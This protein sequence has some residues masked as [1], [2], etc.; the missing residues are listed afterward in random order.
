MYGKIV[1]P[2]NYE[3]PKGWSGVV[4][5]EGEIAEGGNQI[6]TTAEALEKVIGQLDSKIET[7]EKEVVPEQA[8]TVEETEIDVLPGFPEKIEG[9]ILFL[10]ADNI[11]TDAIYPGMYLLEY[12]VPVWHR[13]W[14]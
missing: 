3:R 5:G 13:S 11:S 1:G 12:F 14:V 2:G 7:A 4:I 9:E 10:D 8:A 6:I